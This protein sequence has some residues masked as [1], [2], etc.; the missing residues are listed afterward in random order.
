MTENTAGL[1]SASILLENQVH[2]SPQGIMGL[3]RTPSKVDIGGKNSILLDTKHI[4][5]LSR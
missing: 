1:W 5:N 4:N 2:S 3:M